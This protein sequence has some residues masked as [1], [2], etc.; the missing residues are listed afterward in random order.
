MIDK[1]TDGKD[2]K[3]MED[4]GIRTTHLDTEAREELETKKVTEEGIGETRIMKVKRLKA[5]ILKKLLQQ[6]KSSILMRLLLKKR[7][8]KSK[9]QSSLKKKSIT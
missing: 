9:S 2:I 1:I 3:L 5:R 4:N 6:L 8:K 7:R